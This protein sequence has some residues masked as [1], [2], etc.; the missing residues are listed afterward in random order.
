MFYYKTDDVIK[1]IFVSLF[2]FIL[3]GT[4]W[5]SFFPLSYK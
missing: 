2:F 5:E 4:F 3:P 1:P